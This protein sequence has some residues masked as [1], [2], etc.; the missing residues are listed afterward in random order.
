[1]SQHRLPLNLNTILTSTCPVYGS[2]SHELRIIPAVSSCQSLT[3]GRLYLVSYFPVRYISF[4][5]GGNPANSILSNSLIIITS[6]LV[7]RYH[8]LYMDNAIIFMLSFLIFALHQIK[9]SGHPHS[10]GLLSSFSYSVIAYFFSWSDLPPLWLMLF[11]TYFV[12][13]VSLAHK[14]LIQPS[15]RIFQFVSLCVS[16]CLF[17]RHRGL[18]NINLCLLCLECVFFS[19]HRGF[20]VHRG[21]CLLHYSMCLLS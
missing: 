9:P 15:L 21:L 6:F 16:L 19:I 2:P 1:M 7:Y 13:L 14:T 10:E 18:S 5:V 4:T 17:C 3:S 20:S 11:Y 8:L 12:S